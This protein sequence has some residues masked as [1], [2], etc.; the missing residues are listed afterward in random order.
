MAASKLLAI[1]NFLLRFVTSSPKHPRLPEYLFLAGTYFFP[2]V[3][4][5]AIVVLDNCILLT[6]RDDPFGNIG[7]HL[8]GGIV[9]PNEQINE[10]LVQVLQTELDLTLPDE[11]K[12]ELL[13]YSEIF[14]SRIPSIRSHFISL[15][16]CIRINTAQFNSSSCLH[17]NP[18]VKLFSSVPPNLIDNHK[19]YS[20]LIDSCISGNSHIEPLQEF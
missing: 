12:F 4:V 3:N 6:W 13:G 1:L 7:W 19:R 17:G 2:Q 16:Y 8:P 10:R 11:T 14:S 20:Q 18:H 15:V 5:E 9:R